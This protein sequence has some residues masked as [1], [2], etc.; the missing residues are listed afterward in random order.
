MKNYKKKSIIALPLILIISVL[1]AEFA[2]IMGFF[3]FSLNLSSSRF[4]DAQKALSLAEKCLYQEIS[5]LM[6][7]RDHQNPVS[8]PP[9]QVEIDNSG[10]QVTITVKATYRKSTKKIR[11][12]LTIDKETG[13]VSLDSLKEISI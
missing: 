12:I 4:N 13:K 10:T 8:S 2:L 3:A 11:A 1:V 6:K 7:D 9:C 5:A